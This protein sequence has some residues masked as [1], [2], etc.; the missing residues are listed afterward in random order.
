MLPASGAHR[1]DCSPEKTLA[2]VNLRVLF[3]G[4]W[5]PGLVEHRGGTFFSLNSI[6]LS[7]VL[8]L[9]DEIANCLVS[10]VQRWTK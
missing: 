9:G 2:C 10:A 4:T 5:S 8:L 7:L 1:V 6:K 3:N